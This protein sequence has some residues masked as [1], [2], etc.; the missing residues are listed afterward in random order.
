MANMDYCK[1]ENTYRD[2][3]DC[4]S[5]INEKLSDREHKYRVMLLD[6]CTNMIEKYDEK[7]QPEEDLGPEYD[8]AGFSEEDR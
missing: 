3:V 8:S 5:S 2:L 6:I 7:C 1:F 4:H